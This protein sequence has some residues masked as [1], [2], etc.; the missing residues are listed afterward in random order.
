LYFTTIK[1]EIVTLRFQEVGKT[2]MGHNRK[3]SRQEIDY[4]GSKEISPQI[5]AFESLVH[6]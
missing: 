6:N 3:E 5:Q 4:G 2:A 1:P